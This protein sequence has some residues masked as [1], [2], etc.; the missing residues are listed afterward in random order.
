MIVVIICLYLVLDQYIPQ[1]QKWLS[2]LADVHCYLEKAKIL[3]LSTLAFNKAK[4]SDVIEILDS[5][6]KILNLTPKMVD[7]TLML[8]K[9][10]YLT[11][12]N[13]RLA[14]YQAKFES[15]FIDTYQ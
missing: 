15:H 6:I 10:N 2:L 5:Y 7:N 3:T 1:Y 13:L 14:I 8:L 9:R 11:I 12:R 4:I